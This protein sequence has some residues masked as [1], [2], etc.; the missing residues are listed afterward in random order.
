[1]N[2]E[3]KGNIFFNFHEKLNLALLT[4]KNIENKIN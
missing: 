2:E 3:V 1:M 4:K